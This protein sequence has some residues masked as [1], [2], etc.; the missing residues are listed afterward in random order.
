MN[1]F[2]KVGI[3]ISI[4]KLVERFKNAVDFFIKFTYEADIKADTLDV[5]VY[6]VTKL[7][8][9][10]CCLNYGI[11]LILSICKPKSSCGFDDINNLLLVCFKKS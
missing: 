11:I 9:I 7:I 8:C 10:S 4:N 3:F 2:D 6:D 5:A 1:L